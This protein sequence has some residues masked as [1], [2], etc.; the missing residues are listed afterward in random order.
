MSGA[1]EVVNDLIT[2]LRERLDEDG[3][4]ATRAASLCGCHSDAPSWDFGD[5]ATDGRVVVVDDPHPGVKRKLSRRWS[6]TYDGLFMAQHIV[7]HDPARVLREV[8]RDRK[9]IELHRAVPYRSYD[10]PHLICLEC[11]SRDDDHYHVTDAP[12][13]TLRLLALPYASHREYRKE[14][15]P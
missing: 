5:D 1:T 10:P 7:R 6:S 14:W 8:E 2:F 4:A 13:D 3:Y 9:L 12:C 11:S 15:K